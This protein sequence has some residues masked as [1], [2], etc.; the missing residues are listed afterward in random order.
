ML[1]LIIAESKRNGTFKLSI[2]P[3]VTLR[4]TIRQ[5]GIKTKCIIVTFNFVVAIYTKEL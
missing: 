2:K 1:W 3:K 5:Y 4:F